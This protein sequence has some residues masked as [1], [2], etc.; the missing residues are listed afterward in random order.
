M[1][2]VKHINADG[3][4]TIKHYS[5]CARFNS[6]GAMFE[7]AGGEFVFKAMHGGLYCSAIGADGKEVCHYYSPHS[8]DPGFAL[9]IVIAGV[10]GITYC[11]GTGPGKLSC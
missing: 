2:R 7:M 4:V 6:S 11:V 8:Q 3:A 10:Y 5:R 9:D 1:V